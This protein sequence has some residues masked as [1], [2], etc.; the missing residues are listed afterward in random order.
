[1]TWAAELSAR[2]NGNKLAR[3]G[4]AL[5]SQIGRNIGLSDL[6]WGL[7]LLGPSGDRLILD[8]LYAGGAVDNDGILGAPLLARW[9]EDLTGSGSSPRLVWTL[10]SNHPMAAKIGASYTEAILGVI[11]SAKSELVMTS[12]FMQEH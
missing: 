8:A 10:P 2:L 1:M 4:A 6:S 11:G 12:P 9:L 3:M 7:G 5:W